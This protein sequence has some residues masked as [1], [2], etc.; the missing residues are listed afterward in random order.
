M[1]HDEVCRYSNLSITWRWPV[2]VTARYCII[3]TR[4]VS[5]TQSVFAIA[6]LDAVAILEHQSVRDATLTLL[7]TPQILISNSVLHDWKAV[8]YLITNKLTN[9]P[10]NQ[11]VKDLN[12]KLIVWPTELIKKFSDPCNISLITSSQMPAIFP[13]SQP[14]YLDLYT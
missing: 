6:G 13:C 1:H 14:H 7:F 9:K 11:V 5:C 2:G 10:Y 8:S 4:R 12:W 3:P